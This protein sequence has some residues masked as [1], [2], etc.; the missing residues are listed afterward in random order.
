MKFKEIRSDVK[1]RK[2]E[3]HRAKLE[4]KGFNQNEHNPAFRQHHKTTWVT[5][6]RFPLNDFRSFNSPFEVLFNFPSGYL[7]AIDLSS[8]F[9]HGWRL[10]PF[11]RSTPK[12]RDSVE[13]YRTHAVDAKDR[14]I[15]FYGLGA[16]PGSLDVR[17]YWQCP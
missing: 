6:T 11:L 1:L 9:S 17:A 14:A 5:A 15:T 4:R 2:V 8:I 13:R 3:T 10:P 7:F 16:F 12:E